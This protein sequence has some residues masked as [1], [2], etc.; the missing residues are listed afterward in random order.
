[1][2]G[3]PRAVPCLQIDTTPGGKWQTKADGLTDGEAVQRDFLIA[4]S[5]GYNGRLPVQCHGKHKAVI[6]IRMVA[7]EI[8]PPWS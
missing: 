3:P 8:H 7:D 5:P 1:M 2:V 4:G 6:I